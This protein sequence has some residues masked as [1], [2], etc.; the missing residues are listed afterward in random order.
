MATVAENL[1]GSPGPQLRA[2]CSADSGGRRWL[3]RVPEIAA[4]YCDDW[5]LETGRPLP[6]SSA[7]VL[8]A[9]GAQG[10][11]LLLKICR[12]AEAG[13]LEALT[14]QSWPEISPFLYRRDSRRGALLME[15]IR[16]GAT[17]SD[18]GRLSKASRM[19]SYM[20][21]NPVPDRSGIPRLSSQVRRR[22]MGL[23]EEL[24]PG[25]AVRQAALSSLGSGPRSLIHG[26]FVPGGGAVVSRE[27]WVLISPRPA[28]G[29]PAYDA[30]CWAISDL[31]SG[32]IAFNCAELCRRAEMD[33]DRVRE[34]A[35]IVA[36]LE[37]D[38]AGDDYQVRLRN[39]ISNAA[40]D[41]AVKELLSA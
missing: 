30:A 36:A 35:W 40:S 33:E 8:P 11:D 27:G 12:R 17:P 15:R 5:G 24:W 4:V 21:A 16:P 3:S 39:F 37:L 29:D 10:N 25:S 38:F 31:A 20:A 23:S 1:T 26:R 32:S 9:R 13:R 34:V 41:P 28:L 19:L 18:A 7:F 22:Q 6:S 2:S 14:Y